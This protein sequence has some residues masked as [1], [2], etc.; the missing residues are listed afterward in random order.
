MKN[1]RW[2]LIVSALCLAWPGLRG[3]FAAPPSRL[4]PPLSEAELGF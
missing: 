1:R 4:R 3:L 2:L